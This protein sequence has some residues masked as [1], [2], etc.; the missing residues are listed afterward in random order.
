[1]KV[2][3]ETLPE[4]QVRLQIEVDADRHA[5]ALEEAYKRLAP[6]VQIAGFRPGKAPRPLIERQLGRH[7]LLDE[8]MDILLPKVYS[9]AIE[10]QEL[11]PVANPAVELVSH[12]PFVFKAT[13]PLQPVI[14]LGDYLAL[15]VPREKPAATDEQVE[16]SLT[17]LRRR[18]GTIEPVDRPAKKGDVIRG[19]L[20][21]EV[22]GQALFEQEEIEYRLTDESLSSLPGLADAVVGLKKAAEV[23]KTAA[24]PADFSDSRLAGKTVTYRVAVHDVKE[25]KLAALDDAFAKEVGEGFESLKA[26]RNRVRDDLQRQLDDAALHSYEHAVLDALVALATLEY[27]SVL[28]EREIDHILEDQAG[29]DPR[30]PQAQALYLQ[31]LGKSEQEVR[32]SVR[33]E[34]EARLRRSLVLSKFAEAENTTVDDADVEAE[35]QTMAASAGEQSAAIL[36]LFGSESGR[37]S[38]RRSL[39]TRK[40]LARLVEI[41]GEEAPAKPKP[42]KR[43]RSAPRQSE[44]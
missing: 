33:E 11:E 32:D 8:A 23:E 28:V 15:R 30:D 7:R 35:L 41:A 25:E 42:A 13:V 16:E 21:A 39:F 38:L 44:E 1:L 27:P 12:E 40:T 18:Y 36:R 2:T 20:R 6:R 10:E 5:Q 14:D 3:T 17:D 31:R 4:R 22:D 19:N 9:E 29:L 24:A 37:D 43:R 26:L 34:A